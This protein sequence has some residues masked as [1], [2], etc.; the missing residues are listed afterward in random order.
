MFSIHSVSSK[1]RK[2]RPAGKTRCLKWTTMNSGHYEK[3]LLG[4]QNPEDVRVQMPPPPAL[5]Q[6]FVTHG[7]LV[8]IGLGWFGWLITCRAH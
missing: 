4:M 8:R 6:W 3:S 1:V 2:T 7:V 5:D